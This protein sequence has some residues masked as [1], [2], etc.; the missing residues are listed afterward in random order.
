MTEPHAGTDVANYKTNTVIN[1]DRV[2]LNGVKTL[3][4]RADEAH[5]FIVFTR[6]DGK[7][8]REGIGCVLVDPKTPGLRGDRAL[9]HD[10]RREPGRDPVQR[11]R[12][13]ASRT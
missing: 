7:P 4:S 13:A 6:V 8:G 9:S 12:A 1:D 3:I 11:H 10:G 2:V 5:C